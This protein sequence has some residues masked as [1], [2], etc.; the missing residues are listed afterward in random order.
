M[1]ATKPFGIGEGGA[2]FCAEESAVRIRSALNFGLPTRFGPSVSGWGINGKLSEAHAAVGLAVLETLD[3]R[4]ARR[5][6]LAARYIAR[7][8]DISGIQFPRDPHRSTWQVFPVLMPSELAATALV[9][10]AQQLGMEVRRYYRPSLTQWVN[11]TPCPN[12]DSMADRMICFPIYSCDGQ[13]AGDM[14]DVVEASITRALQRAL[15]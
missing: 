12:S 9:D 1:H 14:A 13:M 11:G 7:L 10:S 8:T 15:P 2:I 6:E 4:L 3:A 5:R